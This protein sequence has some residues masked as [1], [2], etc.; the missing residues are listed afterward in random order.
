VSLQS[1]KNPLRC[2]AGFALA[3]SLAGCAAP[4]TKSDVPL[5]H[6][7]KVNATATEAP[8]KGSAFTIVPVRGSVD[9]STLLYAEATRVVTSALQTKGLHAA[10]H[11]EKADVIVEIEYGMAP[12]RVA[13]RGI[14][15]TP[16][17]AEPPPT[18]PRAG[19]PTETNVANLRSAA[20]GPL[21]KR[22]VLTAKE[23]KKITD[24]SPTP[25]RTL[26]SVELTTIDLSNDIR[27][28]F[29]ILASVALDQMG[30]DSGGSQL[31]RVNENDKTVVLLKKTN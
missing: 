2:L 26:W 29:P 6:V 8:K 16:E 13:S 17:L 18:P 31:V 28:Y 11:V 12:P 10:P 24:D 7:V 14:L 30:N 19:V 4:Q 25:P 20:R 15:L 3:V 21:E 27:R 22:L 23:A 1:Q 9:D 5:T